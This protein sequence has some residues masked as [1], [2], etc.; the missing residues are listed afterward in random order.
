MCT[1]CPWRGPAPSVQRTPCKNLSSSR[2]MNL[3]VNHATTL[4]PRHRGRVDRVGPGAYA[5]GTPSSSI[6]LTR[7]FRKASAAMSTSASWWRCPPPWP[8]ASATSQPGTGRRPQARL[9]VGAARENG[10]GVAG[11]ASSSSASWS[12]TMKGPRA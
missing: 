8:G 3:V 10:H 2:P 5:P 12:V 9:L 11:F 4:C 7:T 6:S 1:L